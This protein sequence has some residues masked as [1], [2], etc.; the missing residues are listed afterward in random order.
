MNARLLGSKVPSGAGAYNAGLG[1][2]SQ[3]LRCSFSA[4]AWRLALPLGVAECR[5]LSAH[6]S[7]RGFTE[8][9]YCFDAHF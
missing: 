9:D 3:G 6:L 2:R 5:S 1:L 8:E 4:A 7:G